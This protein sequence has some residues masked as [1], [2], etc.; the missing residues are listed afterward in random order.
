MIGVAVVLSSIA[1]FFMGIAFVVLAIA[2]GRIGRLSDEISRLA[3]TIDE[4][5]GPT[6]RD[7]R[8]AVNSVDKLVSRAAETME[9]IDR[10]AKEVERLLD[11][12]YVADV[13]E[14]VAKT[15][16]SGI[17]SVYEGV[18]QGIR[19]L[20]GTRATAKEVSGNEQR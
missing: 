3:R 10:V 5:V 7:I 1:L 2:L 4:E 15:S 16:V 18:K 14:K 9:R 11:V 17:L 8:L 19:T 13:A 6:A 20:R 12:A